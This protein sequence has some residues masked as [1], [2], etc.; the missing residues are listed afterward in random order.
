MGVV[1]REREFDLFRWSERV[2]IGV[3][4]LAGP[5][6]AW[7]VVAGMAFAFW[8]LLNLLT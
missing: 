7:A 3:F 6:L 8:D 2:P 4:W 1:L 5:L